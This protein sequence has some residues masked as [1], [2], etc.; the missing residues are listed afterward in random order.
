MTDGVEAARRLDGAGSKWDELLVGVLN[1]QQCVL[2]D[3]GRPSEGS[4]VRE[5]MARIGAVD[6]CAESPDGFREFVGLV[7]RSRAH[8]DPHRRTISAAFAV[9]QAAGGR[10]AAG[11]ARDA[12]P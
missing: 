10:D 1:C 3:L 11:Q 7:T 9:R 8:S 2:R 6:R 12:G 4:A 5:V